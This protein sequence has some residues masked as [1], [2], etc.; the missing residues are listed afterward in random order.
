VTELVV[1]LSDF[2]ALDTTDVVP[3]DWPRLPL[4]ESLLA[5]AG[6]SH[7][8]VDWRGWLAAR[9]APARL[10]GLSL[11]AIA[12]TAFR[13]PAFR[14]AERTGY[15]LATPVHFFAS[16]DSI[17]IHPQGLLQ[18]SAQEQDAL[19]RDFAKVFA[20]SPWGIAPLGRRELLL[21][22]PQI[23]ANGSDPCCF[24]GADPH[25]GL[26]R[27]KDAG[28][29]RRL[30]SEIEMWLYEHPIN[31]AREACGKLPVSG[32]WLWGSQP[33]SVP[34]ISSTLAHADLFGSDIYAEALWR[35]QRQGTLSESAALAAIEAVPMR[36][37]SDSVWLYECCSESGRAVGL[38]Q[39]EQRVLPNLLRALR[40]RRLQLLRL[41]AGRHIYTL[42]PWHLLRFWRATA[43]WWEALA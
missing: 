35:S 41:I 10:S 6:A 28:M 11:A 3:G 31:R 4:L 43:A 24:I 33:P 29:L 16:L 38:T 19:T 34:A 14:A 36:L 1:I 42:S 23:D 32:L 27:G 13:D 8:L 5:R 25:A 9:T 17:R 15:W 30:A 12:A 21:S 22:G 26:A 20:D 37:Q 39:L 7:D 2:C 18:L 40:Q